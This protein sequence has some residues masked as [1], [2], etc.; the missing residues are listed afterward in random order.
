MFCQNCG[1]QMPADAL[2]C[3]ECGTRIAPPPQN[4][5]GTAPE[6]GQSRA[7]M[8]ER[9]VG[10]SGNIKLCPDGKYRWIYEFPLLKNPTVLF[11]VW[12]V[13]AIGIL[14]PTAVVCISGFSDGVLEA[15]VSS[16]YV[17]APL[18]G[19]FM[20]LS[21]V[22]YITLAA[23]YGWKYI[24][25]FEMDDEQVVHAQ[26]PRQF[27]KAEA[28]GWLAAFTGA[29]A[30]NFAVT[31][32]G[33]LA[34]TKN[35]TTSEFKK[36]GTVIGQRRFNTIKVNQPLSRNQ[37]YVDKADYDF[38]WQHITSRCTRAKIK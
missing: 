22:G 7:A 23:S 15:L 25:L 1:S 17:F 34:A 27:K 6:P 29:A 30:N 14:V 16:L 31:G 19:I 9:T 12:K 2:F 35:S 28:L 10:G 21:L 33:L 36:V 3:E 18:M 20:V 13:L 32:V 4:G 24:V 8:G 38:V 11:T 37:V 26:Q 5:E